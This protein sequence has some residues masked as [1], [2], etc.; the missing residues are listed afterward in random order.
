MGREYQTR[1]YDIRHQIDEIQKQLPLT[2]RLL[3][4]E[5]IQAAF[6]L[7]K[8]DI[9]RSEQ[10]LHQNIINNLPS[11]QACKEIILFIDAIKRL[12]DDDHGAPINNREKLYK[13]YL[14]DIE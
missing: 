1:L 14:N 13:N 2:K 4:F 9:L 8:T 10:I 3:Y 5:Q 7:Y 12:L 11:R 6:L